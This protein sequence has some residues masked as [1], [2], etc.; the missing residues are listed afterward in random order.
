MD[1]MPPKFSVSVLITNYNTWQLSLLSAQKCVEVDGD[2]LEEILVYDDGS[3]VPQTEEFPSRVRLYRASENLGLTKAL[4]CAFRM[5]ESDVIVLFDSDAY[6]LA[7]FVEEL[8]RMFAADEHLGLVA[9]P[10]V[11]R[12]G[13]RTESYTTEPNLWSLLLGQALFARLEKLLAD[14]SGRISVFTCAMA[15]RRKTFEAVGGFDPNFD[16][17]DLDHDLSMKVNRSEWTIV[18]GKKLKAFH[19]G[20]GTPQLTSKRVL[21]FYKTRWYLLRKF[22]KV[23]APWLVKALILLRLR[24]ELTVLQLLGRRFYADAAT[25]EDKLK[26][27]RDLIEYCREN[28]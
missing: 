20:G 8:R 4:N 14:R 15:I 12:K 5:P 21:R 24:V 13:Q 16:W 6:P 3:T 28:Y 19:E 25:H 18:V 11:G 2:N 26:G 1:E 10:T 23:P 17:L 22:G 7:P 27:R 9:F